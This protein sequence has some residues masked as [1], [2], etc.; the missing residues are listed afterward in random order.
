M[1]AQDDLAAIIDGAPVQRID[2]ELWFLATGGTLIDGAAVF[3]LGVAMPLI[4]TRF[5]M[6][7]HVQGLLAAALVFGAVAGAAIGGPMA[8]RLGRRPLM[9]LDMAVII[10]GGA[11]SG[12]AS[13]APML[14]FGQLLMG[15]GIGIDFPVSASYVAEWMP[16]KIRS[17]MMVATIAFQSVGFIVAA[18]LCLMLIG[19]SSSPALWRGFFLSETA[20]ALLFLLMRIKL[21]ESARWLASVGRIAEARQALSRV[22][23]AGG[24]WSSQ[25]KEPTPVTDSHGRGYGALFS[26]AYRKRTALAALPWF[27]MDIATYGIGLFTPVILGA[28]HFGRSSGGTIAAELVD[29]KGSGSIDMFLLIGFLIGLVTVPRFGRIRMQVIGF[30]LMAAAMGIL[31]LAVHMAGEATG[32]T[33]AIFAAFVLFNLAMN[34]GP[35]ATTFAMA[36]ALFPTGLRA[37]ANGFAAAVAKLGATLSVFLLPIIKADFGIP[38]VLVLM[39]AVSMVGA[40]STVILDEAV[41]DRELP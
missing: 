41:D 33:A 31:I 23:A 9:L 12:F 5:A 38:A 19:F 18:G 16:R 21:P 26:P 29:I 13:G 32:K 37:S 14:I 35:N 40:A 7:A 6:G 39:A 8:D 17:R 30:L 27:L 25:R 34:A 15:L 3:T 22:V 24:G 11:M 1:P 28:I 10:A 4:V 20:L 2:Y 36:S